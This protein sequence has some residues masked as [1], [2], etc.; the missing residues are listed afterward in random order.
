[1]NSSSNWFWSAINWSLCVK[2]ISW[3]WNGH[4]LIQQ[5]SFISKNGDLKMVENVVQSVSYLP[6]MCVASVPKCS[7]LFMI[8]TNEFGI[9]FS[10]STWF[11]SEKTY[12]HPCGLV[13][14]LLCHKTMRFCQIFR[15]KP[16]KMFCLDLYIR[17]SRSGDWIKMSWGFFHHFKCLHSFFL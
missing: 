13:Q 10:E 7:N 1:M 15:Q 2:R 17:C 3:I 9:W 8:Y 14:I 5:I 11:P 4:G 16:L 12:F 6:T